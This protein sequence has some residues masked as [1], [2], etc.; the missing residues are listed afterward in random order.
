M[1]RPHKPGRT[2]RGAGPGDR[3]ATT[4]YLDTP[5][6]LI[7]GGDNIV[8]GVIDLLGFDAGVNALDTAGMQSQTGFTNAELLAV[9]FELM[10]V[11]QSQNIS[12]PPFPNYQPLSDDVAAAVLQ[13][14]AMTVGAAVGTAIPVLG[15]YGSPGGVITMDEPVL[16]EDGG[17]DVLVLSK[18]VGILDGGPDA[19]EQLS[20]A[21]SFFLVGLWREVTP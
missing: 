15:L 8:E 3:R 1:Q 17:G 6:T 9:S 2:G 18:P 7:N 20:V 16:W 19:P 5:G 4:V 12:E 10:L 11:L 13:S 14:T 21:A